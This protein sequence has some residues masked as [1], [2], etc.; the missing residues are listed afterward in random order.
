MTN[1]PI[2]LRPLDHGA[3][4]C[5]AIL[6]WRLAQLVPAITASPARPTTAG[7]WCAESVPVIKPRT[8]IHAACEATP[9]KFGDF[10]GDAPGLVAGE[11]LGR[12]KCCARTVVV[13]LGF[14][15]PSL[16]CMR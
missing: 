2:D 14:N 9:R 8:R 11:Q 7:S 16:F 13:S 12:D 5:A 10:G 6:Q 1:V 3:R 15:S 4:R